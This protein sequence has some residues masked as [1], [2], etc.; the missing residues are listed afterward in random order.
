VSNPEAATM[1]GQYTKS[2]VEQA[3]STEG[4]LILPSNTGH[5]IKQLV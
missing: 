1:P 4:S 5:A 2:L 3:L